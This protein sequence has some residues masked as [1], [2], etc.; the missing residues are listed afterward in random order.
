MTFKHVLLSL[1]FLGTTFLASVCA[2]VPPQEKPGTAQQSQAQQHLDTARQAL[3][4]HDYALVEKSL[5]KAG[6]AD[7]N[8]AEVYRVWGDYHSLF[9]RAWKAE[10]FY[11][12]AAELE[13]LQAA[14][15]TEKPASSEGR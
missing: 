15:K 10:K 3:K 13:E 8:L 5:K 14:K 2:S 6:K 12:K 9:N 4:D 1:M 7:P 11:K